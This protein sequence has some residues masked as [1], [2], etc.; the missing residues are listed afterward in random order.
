MK[1]RIL[2][3]D[4]IKGILIILMVL[5]HI[6]LFTESHKN[7]TEWV[8]CFHMSGFLLISGYLQNIKNNKGYT[9]IIRNILVPYL[10][11]EFVYL[12][13][14]SLLG[15]FLGSENKVEMSFI[16]LL[17]NL[18]LLPKGT[19]W[20]LHTIFICVSI[21][22]LIQKLRLTSYDSIFVLSGILFIISLFIKG[23]VWS[24]IIYFIIGYSMNALNVKFNILIRASL[25]S[26][27][28]IILITFYVKDLNRGN[29]SG[30]ILTI[31]IMSL[32]MYLFNHLYKSINL[33]MI[34][35][36]KNSLSIVLFSPIYLILTKQLAFLFIFD[37]SHLLFSFFS[38]VTVIVLSI[39]SAWISDKL[40]LSY[41]LIGK[42]MYHSIN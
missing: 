17:N 30:V 3:I 35:I 34:Y 27:I 38:L 6:P 42:Q 19:Y 23:F 10:I 14:L 11:F 13:G 16:A 9:Y 20:Y 36:G 8:Y 5:F 1:G 33:L 21:G 37:N 40:N 15:N 2:E 4:F 7:L 22:Y 12:I 24:N 29:F 31:S 41:L 26:L 32:M 39:L 18:I 28:P 25:Y